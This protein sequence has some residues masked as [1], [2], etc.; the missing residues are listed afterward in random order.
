MSQTEYLSLLTHILVL[1]HIHL[2]WEV[3]LLTA[4]W[5][6]GAWFFCSIQLWTYSESCWAPCFSFGGDKVKISTHEVTMPTSISPFK[7]FSS[8]STGHWTNTWV[9]FKIDKRK[10]TK[11]EKPAVLMASFVVSL[12]LGA[13]VH[14]VASKRGICMFHCICVCWQ[15]SK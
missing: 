9:K 10:R 8:C 2:G 4:S 15:H 6:V 12:S 14:N 7:G 5:T 1:K 3:E 13:I 11:K